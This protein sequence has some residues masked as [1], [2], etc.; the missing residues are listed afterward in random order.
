MKIQLSHIAFAVL[1][2]VALSTA[3]PVSA[4]TNT[5]SNSGSL[6]HEQTPDDPLAELTAAAE[7]GDA[8]AMYELAE[9]WYDNEHQ[10]DTAFEWYLR[11]A[12]AGHWKAQYDAGVYYRT[13][14]LGFV[15]QDFTEAVKWFLKSAAQG[16]RYARKRLIDYYSF[17]GASSVNWGISSRPWYAADKEMKWYRTGVAQGSADAQFTLGW[18]HYIGDKMKRDYTEA[19]RLF[20]LSAE[21]GHVISKYALY[22]CYAGGHGVAKDMAEA[23]K[24]RTEAFET[25]TTPGIPADAEELEYMKYAEYTIVGASFGEG[26]FVFGTGND[27]RFDGH[28]GEYVYDATIEAGVMRLDD[29][30]V[31][32]F[33]VEDGSGDGWLLI[34][35][36]GLRHETTGHWA[37]DLP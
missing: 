31:F 8:E 9:Y 28:V 30:G 24:W 5:I 21:Q 13:G 35:I 7:A 2:S 29:L 16:N 32:R 6:S 22:L 17:G 11:A 3:S 25:A 12:G 18:F 20:R 10:Y 23:E 19:V 15:E 33:N 36:D 27:V 26:R 14:F 37:I 34:K 1:A 4:R